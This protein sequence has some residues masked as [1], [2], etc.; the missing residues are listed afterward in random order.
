[1]G[2][3]TTSIARSYWTVTLPQTPEILFSCPIQVQTSGR[4]GQIGLA[5]GDELENGD[6]SARRLRSR[7]DLTVT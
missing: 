5:I 6:H 4:S 3:T 1:M 7:F 2:Q